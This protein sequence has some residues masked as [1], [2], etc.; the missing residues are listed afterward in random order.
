MTPPPLPLNPGDRG[1]PTG[2]LILPCD[3][4]LLS[5]EYLHVARQLGQPL[6]EFTLGLTAVL[7]QPAVDPVRQRDAALSGQ[8]RLGPPRPHTCMQR[9]RL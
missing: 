7:H 5:T 1:P 9:T 3:D 4:F 6:I 8:L 2:S